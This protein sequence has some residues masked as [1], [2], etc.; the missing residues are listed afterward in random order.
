[1]LDRQLFGRHVEEATLYLIDSAEST[2]VLTA[3]Q[4]QLAWRSPC[5]VALASDVYVSSDL[6]RSRYGGLLTAVQPCL[7]HAE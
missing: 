3:Y 1:L 7:V 4:V 5:T 2:T 6:A